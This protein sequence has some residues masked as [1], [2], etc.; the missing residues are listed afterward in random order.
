[1]EQFLEDALTYWE[2]KRA[3]RRMPARRDLDPVLEIPNLLRWI[4]LVDV[5]RVQDGHAAL[6]DEID[7]EPGEKEVGERG[8]AVL[9]DV[10][11]EQHPVR[12]Q[13][14][15]EPP[16]RRVVLILRPRVHCPETAPLDIVEFEFG[17]GNVLLRLRP[18]HV[19]KRA[20]PL[21]LNKPRPPPLSRGR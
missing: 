12:E 6:L 7:W 16:P 1:M 21:P 15:D 14:L 5:L 10:D 2:S 18:V 8:D 17:S 11:P 20:P 19:H 13:L 4:I 3:G 9:R